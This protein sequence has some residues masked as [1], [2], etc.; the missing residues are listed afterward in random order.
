MKYRKAGQ[1]AEMLP[2]V[3]ALLSV[4]VDV[5]SREITDMT[6]RRVTHR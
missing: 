3:P 2:V 1:I 6:G 5:R 4:A